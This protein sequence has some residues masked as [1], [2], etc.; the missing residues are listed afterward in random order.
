MVYRSKPFL[1]FKMAD[2]GMTLAIVLLV[3]GLI[4]GGG[5]GYFA[6]P[7]GGSN[8]QR[9]ITVKVDSVIQSN[10]NIQIHSGDS[11]WTFNDNG[12]DFAPGHTYKIIANGYDIQSVSKIS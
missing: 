4:V 10:N 2:K 1:E 8:G 11:V 6:S 7:S 9:V 12:Y 5:I 3:A